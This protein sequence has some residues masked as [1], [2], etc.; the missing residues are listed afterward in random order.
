MAYRIPELVV[1]FSRYGQNNATDTIGDTQLSCFA[2]SH[3]IFYF[4]IKKRCNFMICPSLL[5][6]NDVIKIEANVFLL[7]FR[8]TNLFFGDE[9]WGDVGR[10]NGLILPFGAFGGCPTK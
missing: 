6:K 9:Q 3:I 10:G 5:S 2:H 1:S 4:I 7:S 8:L